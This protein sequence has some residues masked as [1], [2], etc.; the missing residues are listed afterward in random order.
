MV[1]FIQHVLETFNNLIP[2]ASNAYEVVQFYPW[3]KFFFPLFLDMV[4]YGNA[5]ETKENKI[6][7]FQVLVCLC[8]KTVCVF[9]QLLVFP[10]CFSSY[11]NEFDLHAN[12]R[13]GETRFHL[14]VSFTQRP[15]L[16]QIQTRTQ[17]W[18]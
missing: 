2:L 15:V 6:A 16:A 18:A 10:V 12:G 14:S 13:A 1:Y 3:L 5:F 4:M 8:V 9:K 17:K 7:H 11:E